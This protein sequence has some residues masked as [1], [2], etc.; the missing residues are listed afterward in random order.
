MRHEQYLFPGK[1]RSRNELHKGSTLFLTLIASPTSTRPPFVHS[2]LN[3]ITGGACVDTVHT[4]NPPPSSSTP[5]F[6]YISLTSRCD[7][8]SHTKEND[9]SAHI[10]LNYWV[11]PHTCHSK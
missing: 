10:T 7:H 3:S 11:Q 6:S 5:P 4:S 9:Y 2:A 1:S 8:D